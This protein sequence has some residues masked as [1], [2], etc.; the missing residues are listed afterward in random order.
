MDFKSVIDHTFLKT[1]QENVDLIQQRAAVIALCREA[2]TG[3]VASVCVRPDMIGIAKQELRTLHAPTLITTVI[4]FPDGSTIPLSEKIAGIEKARL[5]G[6]DEFDYVIDF[7]A[8]KSKNWKAL[9]QEAFE[10]SQTA[11]MQTLKVI[12]ETSLWTQDE[13]K[14]IIE[15][16]IKG[17]Q[18]HRDL[19]GSGDR[20]LKTSTGFGSRGAILADITL[21]RKLAP[22]WIGIKASGG[23]KT[24]A[25]A[26]RFWQEAGARSQNAKPDPRLFRIG[27]SSL[28]QQLND[29]KTESGS[30]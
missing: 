30:Y 19:G 20:F 23:V 6:A 1:E 24:A 3:Q 4:G 27:S 8:A 17:W 25:D 21:M 12:V 22:E 29:V 10:L 15:A 28:L 18:K 14:P 9:E 13:L 2:A 5:L 11:G 7:N 16:I 26:E